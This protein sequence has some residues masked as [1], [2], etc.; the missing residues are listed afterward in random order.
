MKSE[1]TMVPKAEANIDPAPEGGVQIDK[2]FTTFEQLISFQPL[3]NIDEL[4]KKIDAK[5]AEIEEEEKIKENDNKIN[6]NISD[7]VPNKEAIA[8]ETVENKDAESKALPESQNQNS[9]YEDNTDDDA[10]FDDFFS[11]D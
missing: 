4:V 5:I 9:L 6:T 1:I 11:D 10:F 3:T 2:K 7:L 8:K